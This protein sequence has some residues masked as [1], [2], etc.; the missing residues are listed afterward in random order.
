MVRQRAHI[1][2]LMADIIRTALCRFR[3]FRLLQRD[4]KKFLVASVFLLPLSVLAI[5][6][7]SLAR[8]LSS[9][10]RRSGKSTALIPY[11]DAVRLGQLVN[12]A[13]QYSVLQANCLPRSVC[14]AWILRNRGIAFDLRIGVAMLSSGGITA[15]AWV[16]YLGYP[17][18]DGPDIVKRFTPI[19]KNIH[20]QAM[21]LK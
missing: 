6:T 14:L 5:R 7:F 20:V 19:T 21:T 11:E 13:A 4:D 2:V 15:H 18:N 3:K 9:I 16:E 1:T 12:T 17:I 10:E 8:I